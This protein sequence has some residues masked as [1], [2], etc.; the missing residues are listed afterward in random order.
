MNH[1]DDRSVTE[2]LR[3]RRPYV[4]F[5]ADPSRLVFLVLLGIQVAGIG[6]Q[7]FQQSV[8]RAVGNGRKVRLFDVF[9]T[10]ARKD[11]A[12]NFHLAVSTVVRGANSADSSKQR[13]EQ[14]GS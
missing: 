5:G 10:Y 6:I 4:S 9:T 13:K 11:F 1:R 8:Q 7:R 14:D 3:H 2:P 12:V